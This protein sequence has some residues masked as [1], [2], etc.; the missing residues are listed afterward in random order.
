MYDRTGFCKAGKDC[1]L[2]H[3]EEE[4]LSPLKESKALLCPTLKET[5]VACPAGCP[6]AHSPAELKVPGL[7]RRV[8]EHRAGSGRRAAD[9]AHDAL[10]VS[11]S[12]LPTPSAASSLAPRTAGGSGRDWAFVSGKASS[13]PPS[14]KSGSAPPPSRRSKQKVSHALHPGSRPLARIRQLL[15]LSAAC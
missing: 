10:S 14:Q 4:I 2:A 8:K 15:A 5:G 13:G 3:G 9:A 11:S 6:F 7:F 1:H 12:S